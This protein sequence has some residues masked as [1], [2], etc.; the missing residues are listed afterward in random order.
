MEYQGLQL[1]H[2]EHDTFQI[3]AGGKVIYLDP[4]NLKEGQIEP[5]DYVFVTHE[6]FDHC[7]RKDINKIVSGKTVVVASQQC[8]DQLKGLRVK[9]LIYVSAKQNVELDDLKVEAVL[10]YNLDKFRL[11]GV[12]Y[13]PKE[14]GKVGYVLDINGVRIYH[15]GDTDNIPEMSDIKNIDIALLPVSGT[16]VMTYLEAIKAC[17]IIKPKVAVPMHYGSIVGSKEDA[18]RFKEGAEGEVEI[19]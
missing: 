8:A 9:E 17:G 12:A 3:K 13:H 7:S 14:D 1:N 18:K 16:Y 11:A 6:H 19:I 15:A 4:Y 5:A 2:F 10:A